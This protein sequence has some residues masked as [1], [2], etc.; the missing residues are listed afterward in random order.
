MKNL[1][2]IGGSHGI[3]LSIIKEL[4][5]TYHLFVTSRTDKSLNHG[6]VTHINFDTT[7][8]ILDVT[9]IPETLNGF[10]YCPGNI[11]LIPF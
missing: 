8:D 7:T 4:Q 3:G 1:L 5:D 2:L 10:V 6:I 9:K 11:D